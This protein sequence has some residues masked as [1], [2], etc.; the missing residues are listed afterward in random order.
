MDPPLFFVF[1]MELELVTGAAY[2]KVVIVAY[3]PL[4]LYEIFVHQHR[5]Q[6][7]SWDRNQ[8]SENPGQGTSNH[9]GCNDTKRRQIDGA[10]H[11][12][13]R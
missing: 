7:C 5:N 8:C 6:R 11:D 10:F 2:F 9:Q 3:D 4:L 12:S 1:A 13:R